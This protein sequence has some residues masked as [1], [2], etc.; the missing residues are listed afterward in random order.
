VIR[1]G[2]E[3]RETRSTSRREIVTLLFEAAGQPLP[4]WSQPS[5][6]GYPLVLDGGRGILVRA[7]AYGVVPGALLL[8]GLVLTRRRRVS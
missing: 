1:V 8:L 6:P 3:S 4:D 2:N 5:Y 7:L